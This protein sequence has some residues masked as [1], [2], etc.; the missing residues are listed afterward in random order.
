MSRS[1]FWIAFGLGAA[2]GGTVALLYAPQ[3]G[4]TTRRRLKRSIEDI[5]DNLQDAGDYLKEQADKLS[6]EAQRLINTS[7]EQLGNAVDTA[8]GYMKAANKAAGKLV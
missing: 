3:S 2:I 8:S 7:K 1:T 4:V 6:K 5:G